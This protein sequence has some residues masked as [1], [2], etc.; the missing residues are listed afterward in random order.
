MFRHD[1]PPGLTN[2]LRDRA[3]VNRWER[4]EDVLDLLVLFGRVAEHPACGP[5][6]RVDAVLSTPGVR[7]RRITWERLRN[8]ERIT[9]GGI[10]NVPLTTRATARPSALS[11]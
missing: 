11:L 5:H 9:L 7:T 3:S 10:A 6:S 2:R 1:E 4:L 8:V